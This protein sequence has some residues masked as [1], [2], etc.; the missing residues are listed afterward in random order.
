V[1][2]AFAL[3]VAASLLVAGCGSS[4]SGTSNDKGASV[5]LV[6]V[7]S[8]LVAPLIKRWKAG[9]E[10]R[11]GS[12]LDYRVA[13]DGLEIRSL[14]NGD[15]AFAT[16]NAPVTP[17]QAR[18]AGSVEMLPWALTGVAVVY[19]L[20]GIPSGLHLNGAVL[21][22]ILLGRIRRWSDPAIDRLNPGLQLPRLPIRA[23]YRGRENGETYAMINYLVENDREFKEQVGMSRE[24]PVPGGSE[25]NSAADLAAAVRETNGA[26]GYVE[27]PMAAS[28]DLSIA[29][30][31]TPGGKF[32]APSVR[33]I[34]FGAKY[35]TRIGSNN[36]VRIVPLPRNALIAYPL[37]AFNYAVVTVGSKYVDE[38]KPFLR[39]A[40]SPA[41]QKMAV[42]IHF[43]PLP[44]ELVEADR[45]AIISLNG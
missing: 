27:L 38:L 20:K 13:D 5:G 17:E 14:V 15:A 26:I 19:N 31:E 12:P 25:V 33:N 11:T 37:V 6:G 24:F 3:A 34:E 4:S 32:A 9:Y 2:H 1:R 36:E 28:S 16:E 10:K 35:G 18:E 23:V 44:Q 45:G 43:V 7:G 40:L 21:A 30:I 29:K 42:G 39:Y 41:A 22:G 8:E